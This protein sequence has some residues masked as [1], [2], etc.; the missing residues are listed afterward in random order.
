MYETLRELF[1]SVGNAAMPFVWNSDFG[2][3]R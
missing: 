2:A 3:L 1:P